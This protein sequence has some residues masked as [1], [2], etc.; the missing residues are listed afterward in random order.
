M[1]ALTL[2][3]LAQSAWAQTTLSGRVIDPSETPVAGISVTLQQGDWTAQAV[4]SARGEFRFD[5][6]RQGNY[7]LLT[8][9]PGFDP[10]RLTVRAGA[11]SRASVTVRLKLAVLKEELTVGG[12]GPRISPQAGENADAISVERT[13][14][15]NLPILDNNYL[16]AL[17]RFLNPG[18]AGDAGTSL[19]VDGMESRNVG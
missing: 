14:L 11:Q 5:N 18:T 13:M 4:T 8:T 2:I 3:L 9:V 15:D 17:S 10:V 16:N 19:I 12:G 1:R 6:V 7:L